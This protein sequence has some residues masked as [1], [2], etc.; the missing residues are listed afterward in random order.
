[1]GQR[2]VPVA[3]RDVQ[4]HHA[5]D[6]GGDRRLVRGATLAEDHGLVQGGVAQAVDVVAVDARL[7]Q[8]LDDL[9]RHEGEPHTTHV[10]IP[11]ASSRRA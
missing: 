3:V 6:Q 1:V 2:G 9:Q 11:P 5:G 10:K 4:C 8:P 7:Q